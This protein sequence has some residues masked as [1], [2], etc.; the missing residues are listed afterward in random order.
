MGYSL[1]A[2][3]PL[4]MTSLAVVLLVNRARGRPRRHLGTVR[5]RTEVM[6]AVQ[7]GP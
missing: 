2:R 7:S 6:K 5:P 1:V 4:A 3:L